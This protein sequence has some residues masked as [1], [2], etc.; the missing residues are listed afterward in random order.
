[1]DATE[2]TTYLT[3]KQPYVTG[4]AGLTRILEQKYLAFA[5]N[6]DHESFF[7]TRRTGVPTYL[8]SSEHNS[9]T[10]YPV[11]WTY[12]ASEDLDNK[13]NYR[14]ALRAQFGAEVDDRDQIIWLLKD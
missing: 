12:P 7:T 5:E 11:R 2:I 3:N 14:A 6:T 9:I 10:R 13:S 4:A 1:V 8:F